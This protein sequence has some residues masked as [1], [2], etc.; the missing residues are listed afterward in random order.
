M[1]EDLDAHSK[2]AAKLRTASEDATR[3]A[4][5]AVAELTAVSPELAAA[6]RQGLKLRAA[7]EEAIG[8]IYKRDVRIA[9]ASVSGLQK[10]VPKF[11]I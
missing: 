7:L 5:A 3:K 11:G 4:T 2:R 10:L 8:G 6:A 9:G 1:A